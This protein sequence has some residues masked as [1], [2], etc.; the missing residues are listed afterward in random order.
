MAI[1]PFDRTWIRIAGEKI[2][3]QRRSNVRRKVGMGDFHSIIQ[4]P[5]DLPGPTRTIPR[6]EDI[7]INTSDAAVGI[8]RRQIPLGLEERIR[9][10]PF[11]FLM[12]LQLRIGG[13]DAG[14]RR[15][16][17]SEVEGRDGICRLEQGE[18]RG[19]RRQ[20]LQ[21]S[22]RHRCRH[23][24]RIH[25]GG[26]SNQHLARKHPSCVHGMRLALWIQHRKGFRSRDR[27]GNR[28]RG[29]PGWDLVGLRFH[30]PGSVAFPDVAL[31]L[32]HLKG[33]VPVPVAQPEEG[34]KLR[35]LEPADHKPCEEK[36]ED[37]RTEAAA[38]RRHARNARQLETGTQ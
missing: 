19:V 31:L 21:P 38:T 7:Q 10:N 24:D 14:N 8:V 3:A 2:V 18:T 37:F 29:R 13:Q 26:E 1:V 12:T 9:R 11:Q 16:C 17:A 34:G 33:S 5:D 32:G 6:G 30:P 20:F 23:V 27:A 15:Q 25:P 35:S 28:S 4:N 36:E 22:P